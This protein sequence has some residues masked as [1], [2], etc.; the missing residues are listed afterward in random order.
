MIYGHSDHARLQ[1]QLGEWLAFEDITDHLFL[2]DLRYPNLWL[3]QWN[4]T[5]CHS[6]LGLIALVS[7]FTQGSVILSSVHQIH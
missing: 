4:I 6:L 7:S 5:S 3:E 2:I 1:F